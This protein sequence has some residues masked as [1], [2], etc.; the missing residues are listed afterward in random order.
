MVTTIKKRKNQYFILS[1]IVILSLFCSI[2]VY[3]EF[4]NH[5]NV[6][7]LE[8]VYQETSYAENYTLVEWQKSCYSEGTINVTNQ[9]NETVYDLYISFLNTASL[10]DNLSHDSTTK[11]GNQTQGQP[12]QKIVIHIPELRQF[13]YSVF[14]Y[15]ISCMGIN[16]P[17]NIETSYENT[18]HGF[19][20]KVLSGYNWTIN[21]T[22]INNNPTNLTITNI[23]ITMKTANVTWND[24]NY[25]FYFEPRLHEFRGI[26]SM[27]DI[28]GNWIVRFSGTQY[29]DIN[30]EILNQV[31]S[32]DDRLMEPVC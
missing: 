28:A 8:Q 29:E 10:S 13:N 14:T 3:A 1:L 21:Q 17:V 4:G 16:P 2:N 7:I 23:N 31:S 30:F 19:N 20:A 9:N 27:D 15:N 12:G 26:C 32:W 11:F 24:T 22:I 5:V 25:N 6:S 18:D